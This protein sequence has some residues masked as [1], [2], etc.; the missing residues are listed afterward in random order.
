MNV[1]VECVAFRSSEIKG[2][3]IEASYLKEPKG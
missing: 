1:V 2:Y 3:V